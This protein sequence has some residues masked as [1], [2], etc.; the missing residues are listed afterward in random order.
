MTYKLRSFLSF[1]EFELCSTFYRVGRL[2]LRVLSQ[3]LDFLAF[4]I[5]QNGAH[6]FR[7]T[8]YFIFQF[9]IDA[10]QLLRVTVV[11][12]INQISP[13]AWL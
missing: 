2:A 1:S 3:I 4:H 12:N 7:E 9:L 8:E 13:T 10:A 11:S 6:L 5:L